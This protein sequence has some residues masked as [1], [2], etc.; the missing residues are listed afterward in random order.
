MA[1]QVADYLADSSSLHNTATTLNERL[2]SG[3]EPEETIV[4]VRSGFW[5]LQSP[6]VPSHTIDADF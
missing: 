6:V 1:V 5:R 3:T 2:L 4:K